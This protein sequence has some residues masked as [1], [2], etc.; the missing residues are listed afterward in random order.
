MADAT[1]LSPESS[2]AAADAAPTFQTP[3]GETAVTGRKLPQQ[4][5]R[6]VVLGAGFEGLTFC[7]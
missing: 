1:T 7:Q 3:T 4:P 6:V 5:V 2:T